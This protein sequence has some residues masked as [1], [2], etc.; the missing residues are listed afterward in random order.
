MPPSKDYYEILGVSRNANEEEIKRAFRRLAFKYHPD[1]NKEPGAEE[2]FKE[3][4]EA[5]EVLSDARKRAIYDRQGRA[6]RLDWA[7]FDEFNFG[8]LGDI[9]DAFFGATTAAQQRVPRKG[10]NLQANLTISFEE[11]I[12]GAEKQ[13]ELWR[14]EACP[15]CHGIGSKPGT[16]PEKCPNCNGKGE[17]RRVQ[18]G[19]FGRFTYSTTCPRCHGEGSIILHPC[20]HCKGA[21]KEKVK[22]TLT[23]NIP[24]G[25]DETYQFHLP[26]QGDAGEYGG[27]PGDVYVAL[28]IK[29]HR[30]FTRKG[31]DIIYE[32]PINFAQ[33]ALGDSIAIPTIEGDAILK[34]PAGTQ[35]D[36][37]FRIK[38]KGVPHLNKKGRGDQAVIVKVV[39]PEYVTSRQRQLFEEL[40][41]TLPTPEIPRGKAFKST[42]RTRRGNTNGLEQD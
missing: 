18:Q 16:N 41:K 6:T 40:A 23:V 33:A 13:L 19:I 8:G 14:V 15:I 3:I 22:R 25:V 10:N 42:D 36:T 34:I 11:A 26:N 21:G 28:S 9:F 12:F 39:T 31:Y 32:L 1:H 17:V 24:P 20:P 7:G 37:V 27:P 35:H 4:N 30:L 2:K 38:G 5:Y 29:P